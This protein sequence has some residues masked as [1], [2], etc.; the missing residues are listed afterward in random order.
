MTATH[1][2]LAALTALAL[3][4]A[5]VPPPCA[6]PPVTYAPLPQRQAAVPNPATGTARDMP[7]AGPIGTKEP[8]R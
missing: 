3:S 2:I 6:L 4:Q 1:W 7:A 8:L 5:P